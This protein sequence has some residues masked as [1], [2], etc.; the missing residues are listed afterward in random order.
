MLIPCQT[1]CLIKKPGTRL[2]LS[3]LTRL[4]TDY[5]EQH[6]RELA[7]VTALYLNARGTREAPENEDNRLFSLPEN[8]DQL[9]RL[10]RLY[11][12]YNRLVQLPSSL[13]K[14][15]YLKKLGV[16]GNCLESLPEEMAQMISLKVLGL[17]NNQLKTLPA[18][19]GNLSNL[20]ILSLDN[21]FLTSLPASVEYLQKLRILGVNHNPLPK[22]YVIRYSFTLCV[23]LRMSKRQRDCQRVYYQPG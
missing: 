21:N 15:K 23:V 7:R 17:D 9:L 5:I 1:I 20:T 10:E 3:F 13:T 19:L 16:E 11:A 4:T 14:L 6:Q 2:Y 22:K 18:E 8:I 12:R